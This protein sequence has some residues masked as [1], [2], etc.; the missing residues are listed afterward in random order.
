MLFRSGVVAMKVLGNAALAAEEPLAIRYSLSLGADTAVVGVQSP[1]EV[2]A[3]VAA[4]ANLAP[5]AADETERLQ[6]LARKAVENRE[7]LP[8]WLTDAQVMAFQPGWHGGKL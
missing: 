4:T 2:E 5:L 3:A 7:G 1:V 8:F 6:A